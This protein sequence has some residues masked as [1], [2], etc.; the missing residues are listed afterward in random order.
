MT[1]KNELEW[2]WLEETVSN[3]SMNIIAVFALGT[4]VYHDKPQNSSCLGEKFERRNSR[5]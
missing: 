4:Q 1:D 5:I 2:I 3:L